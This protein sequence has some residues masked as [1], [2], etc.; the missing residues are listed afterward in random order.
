MH[1]RLTAE[2]FND[3]NNVTGLLLY[4]GSRFAQLVEGPGEGIAAVIGRIGEDRRHHT[5][6]VIEH[7]PTANR[8]FEGWALMTC[9][10]DYD[11]DAPLSFLTR[12]E[13]AV[14][15]CTDA[16]VQA[17]FIGFGSLAR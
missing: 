16:A 10:R 14:Q 12:V 15:A 9:W 1:L 11:D 3:R 4:D 8:Q 2:A 5:L 6:Q 13:L 7:A 17:F